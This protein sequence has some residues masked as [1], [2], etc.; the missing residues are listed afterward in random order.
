MSIVN[1]FEGGQLLISMTEEQMVNVLATRLTRAEFLALWELMDNSDVEPD[2]LYKAVREKVIELA[3]EH[4]N[5][6]GSAPR[7]GAW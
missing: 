2:D 4:F 7:S 6:N 1:V 3:P 5:F